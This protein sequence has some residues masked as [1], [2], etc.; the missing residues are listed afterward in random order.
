M[1]GHSAKMGKRHLYALESQPQDIIILVQM[2]PWN[3]EEAL[4]ERLGMRQRS[5]RTMRSTN[6]VRRWEE[7]WA[8]WSPKIISR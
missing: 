1:F 4:Q 3:S 5:R 8:R 2:V 6:G 7:K